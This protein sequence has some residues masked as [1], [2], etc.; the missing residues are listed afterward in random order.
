MTDSYE[1]QTKKLRE[2]RK[3]HSAVEDRLVAL[4]KKGF[5]E[6]VAVPE[7]SAVLGGRNDLL[8]YFFDGRRVVFEIFCSAGQTP[9]DLRL[10][11]Q[12]DAAVKVAIL[13]DREI[14]PEV[15]RQYFRKKPHAFPFL[16]LRQVLDEGWETI[17]LARLHEI[18]DE[19]HSVVRLR[20]LLIGTHADAVSEA[21][22]LVLG[23]LE[24]RLE[25][26]QHPTARA[27]TGKQVLALQV[28]KLIKDNGI[29]VERLR[30]LF[31]WLCESIEYAIEI[32]SCGF[33]AFLITDLESRHAVWSD[34]DLADD[35]I[36]CSSDS[37][38]AQ[39]VVCMNP[40]I[41]GFLMDH[42]YGKRELRFHFFHSYAE[43]IERIIPTAGTAS[44]SPRPGNEETSD[45]DDQGT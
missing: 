2:G 30:S 10:L 24:S 1:K 41:N 36:V 25:T 29:P 7:V 37:P 42:G 9:Q 44:G 4:L 21:M 8:Q 16:W 33:Q 3:L 5:P 34:G 40:I 27:P 43:F 17:T 19:N 23:S 15:A 6:A 35:L 32:V 20:R 14:D 45:R 31:H 12:C 22:E 28:V 26:P 13:I 18:I 38:K 39:I 11:E